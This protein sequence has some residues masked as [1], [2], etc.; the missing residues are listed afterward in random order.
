MK[1][2]D[3]RSRMPQHEDQLVAW[4]PRAQMQGTTGT[5]R[6][7]R[8]VVGVD[9]SP[10]SIDALR[11][12]ARHAALTGG[13]VESVISWHLPLYGAEYGGAEVDWAGTARETLNLAVRQALN[14]SCCITTRVVRGRPVDV[15]LRAAAGA[16]L[17]VVGSRGFG[18]LLSIL[19]QSVS[20]HVVAQATCPVVVI[21]HH[22]RPKPG[23]W[24][25]APSA[26]TPIRVDDDPS[27]RVDTNPTAVSVSAHERRILDQLELEFLNR[28]TSAAP[29]LARRTA[30]TSP[31]T[32]PLLLGLLPIT[33]LPSLV[34]IT[35]ALG[36]LASVTGLLLLSGVLYLLC[37]GHD[38]PG[39]ASDHH[40][41]SGP[42]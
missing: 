35:T 34:P 18:A 20:K 5:A 21:H 33:L 1:R 39:P 11:W 14:A 16:D 17:L 6:P 25:R 26:C 19:T 30:R 40:T 29:V 8:I 9:G 12:A 32:S 27:R 3:D 24:T 38:D 4:K 10:A 15:L 41:A 36:A 28:Q 37:S 31:H 22:C 2:R 13:T 42:T 7:L 23:G